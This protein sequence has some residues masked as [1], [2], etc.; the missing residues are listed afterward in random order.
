MFSNLLL[1]YAAHIE[2]SDT[3]L[4]QLIEAKIQ[5]MRNGVDA[6]KET[7]TGR[8]C[9]ILIDLQPFT[10]MLRPHTCSNVTITTIQIFSRPYTTKVFSAL[11]KM[12]LS[13]MKDVRM[14]IPNPD[15]FT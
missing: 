10:K 6:Y 4:T 8:Y 5:T 12:A 9:T 15:S 13:I 11:F 14:K 7:L 2:N 3:P 1:L